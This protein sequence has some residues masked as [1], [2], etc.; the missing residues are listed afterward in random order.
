[1]IMEL[2]GNCSFTLTTA[3]GKWNRLRLKNGNLQGSV[4]ARPSL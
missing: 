3:N 4:L 1:M 2:A